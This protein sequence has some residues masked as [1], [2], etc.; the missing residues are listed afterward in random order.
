MKICV[1]HCHLY[2]ILTTFSV[3]A[4]L[5]QTNVGKHCCFHVLKEFHEMFY[6]LQDFEE[7][8]TALLIDRY[9]YL[10]LFPC[11]QTELRSLGYK[12]F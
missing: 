2:T 12:V 7:R 9:K 8:E 3:Q 4:D 1:T 11:S 5:R 10:D 6:F